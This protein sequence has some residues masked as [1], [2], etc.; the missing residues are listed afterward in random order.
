MKAP[1]INKK[2][3]RFIKDNLIFRSEIFS[4]DF[5][6]ECNY[7]SFLTILLISSLVTSHLQHLIFFSVEGRVVDEWLSKLSMQQNCLE[8]MLKQIAEPTLRGFKSTGLRSDLRCCI[9]NISQVID[10][11][12]ARP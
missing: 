10:A 4:T 9:S 2:T 12:V 7:N 6:S 5:I 3:T 8:D 11:F 1:G